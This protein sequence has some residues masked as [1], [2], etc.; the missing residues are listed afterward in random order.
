[1][2]CDRARALLH[3]YLD[4]ELELSPGLE[5]EE[6]LASCARCSTMR[7]DM[8]ALSKLIRAA[9]PYHPAPASVRQAIQ[10][11]TPRAPWPRHLAGPIA[12]AACLALILFGYWLGNSRNDSGEA[13]A[14]DLV[15][16]HVRSLQADH[17]LDVASSDHHTVAPWF[18]G[19]I[20]FAPVV[21]DH[22]DI[23]FPL[24]GGRVDYLNGRNIAALVYRHE[25]HRINVFTWP[26][27]ADTG[28]VEP[29]AS[30][31]QGFT[32]VRWRAAGMEYAATSDASAQTLEQLVKAFRDRSN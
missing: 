14:A 2:E 18:A 31:Q 4:G 7:E 32:V 6:H 5:V 19:H 29:R 1:M 25:R 30:K 28:D 21:V 27:E 3:A 8:T 17:L 15:A 13:L 12:A 24:E 20:D 10:R 16:A 23:G 11:Q 9:A 22:A 26:V